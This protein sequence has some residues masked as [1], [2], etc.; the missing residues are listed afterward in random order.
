MVAIIS[1]SYLTNTIASVRSFSPRLQTQSPARVSGALSNPTVPLGQ[2]LVPFPQFQGIAAAQTFAGQSNYHA[3]QSS[4]Q[5]RLGAGGTFLAAY[6]WSKFISNVD[7][8][9]S[10]FLDPQIGV[11]Q[12]YTNLKADRSE[13]SFGAPN[14]LV[15]SYVADLPIGRGKRFLHSPSAMTDK[16]VSGWQLN[17]ITTFQSGYP[18]PIIAQGTV[19]QSSFYAGAP[20]PNIAPGCTKDVGGAEQGRLTHWFNTSC[21]TQ[22]SGYGFGNEPR[23]DSQVRDSGI[24]NYD[25]ALL[26]TTPLFSERVRFQFTTE[27]FNVFNRVQFGP[28]GAQLGTGSFGVVSSQ[29]NQPRLIQFAGRVVF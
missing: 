10:G 29:Y 9:S 19:L 25:F 7:S 16:L 24:D 5:Q 20:R 11:S 2:L 15:A 28:P 26:K 6:T 27:V 4:F 17:G 23:T 1:T 21:F 3:L 18:V 12:D 13:S 14:R 8:L 22:P